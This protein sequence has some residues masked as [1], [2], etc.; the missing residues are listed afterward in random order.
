MLT[1]R[2]NS[3]LY[4]M[5]LTFGLDHQVLKCDV[6]SWNTELESEFVALN[7]NDFMHGSEHNSNFS[8][9]RSPHL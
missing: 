5:M 1:W 4:V 9:P 6:N 2:I 3:G 8:E 7:V